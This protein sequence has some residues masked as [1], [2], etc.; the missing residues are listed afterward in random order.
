MPR[1][2]M[3]CDYFVYY[4]NKPLPPHFGAFVTTNP[5]CTYSIF[6][7]GS[8]PE[9]V[10]RRALAHEIEHLERGHFDIGVDPVQAERELA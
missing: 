5:D 10:Q 7:D 3:G 1:L 4:L 9:E 6:L 2:I 8:K